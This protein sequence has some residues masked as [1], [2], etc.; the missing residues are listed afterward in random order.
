M[1][2]PKEHFQIILFHYDDVVDKWNQFEWNSD[3]TIM[4]VKALGQSKWYVI[5]LTTFI[6]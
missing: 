2:F 6:F 3:R 4:H 5:D 1:Q